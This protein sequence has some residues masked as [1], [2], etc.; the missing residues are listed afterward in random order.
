MIGIGLYEVY[1]PISSIPVSY[2]SGRAPNV[3]PPAIESLVV[4]R[5]AGTS[6]SNSRN[7]SINHIRRCHAPYLYTTHPHTH[8]HTRRHTTTL[9]PHPE[10]MAVRTALQK[11]K[12]PLQ[13]VLLQKGYLRLT[14]SQGSFPEKFFLAVE[15][16]VRL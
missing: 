2:H 10:N 14:A 4:L 8:T 13:S 6:T 12:R 9:P 15:T 1:R 16:N 11:K 7:T 3:G 5:K